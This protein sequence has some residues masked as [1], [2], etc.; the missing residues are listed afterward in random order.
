M[1]WVGPGEQGG[2]MGGGEDLTL[3]LLGSGGRLPSFPEPPPSSQ[4]TP[5]TSSKPQCP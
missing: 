5:T 3:E 4:W 1:Q 2:G